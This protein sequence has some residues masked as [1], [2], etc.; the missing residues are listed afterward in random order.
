MGKKHTA[1]AKKINDPLNLN[2]VATSPERITAIRKALGDSKAKF[3]ERLGVSRMQ[4]YRYEAGTS[5]PSPEVVQKLLKL[6][7]GLSKTATISEDSESVVANELRVIAFVNEWNA[8]GAVQGELA[9]ARDCS[10]KDWRDAAARSGIRLS[11]KDESRIKALA[12]AEIE[13][14]VTERIERL[15]LAFAILPPVGKLYLK[16]HKPEVFDAFN[17]MIQR[18]EKK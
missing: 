12:D 18:E 6:E 7:M 3:A 17:R 11:A 4:A 2:L 1:R 9:S 10:L 16:E 15:K 13:A 8:L 14:I 5:F